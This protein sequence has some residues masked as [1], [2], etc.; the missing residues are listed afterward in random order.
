MRGDESYAGARSFYTF[1]K[2]V[3]E[4]TGYKHILPVHQG[5]AAE[6]I[7]LAPSLLRMTWFQTILTLIQRNLPSNYARFTNPRG[8]YR[9]PYS[10]F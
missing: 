9:R 4:I 7:F 1:E 10:P 2:T 6:R 3:K 8:Q 5:R